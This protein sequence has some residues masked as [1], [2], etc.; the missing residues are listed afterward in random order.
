MGKFGVAV[1]AMALVVTTGGAGERPLPVREQVHPRWVT[2]VG[3]LHVPNL[4]RA[5]D[6]GN[7]ESV[8]VC[9]DG[10]RFAIRGGAKEFWGHLHKLDGRR[11]VLSGVLDE[12]RVIQGDNVREAGKDDKDGATVTLDGELACKRPGSAPPTLVWTLTVDDQTF[13]LTLTKSQTDLA[14]TLKWQVRVRGMLLKDGTVKVT[15][16]S[17]PRIHC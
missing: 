1:A 2:V 9:D 16:L 11:A 13:R 12:G 8:I 10:Q 6:C 5:L 3:K 4:R 14:S 15:S 17:D 7:D